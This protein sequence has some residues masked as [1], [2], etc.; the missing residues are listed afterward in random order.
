VNPHRLRLAD[1]L[2]LVAVDV[3]QTPR[4]EAG[5]EADVLLECSGNARA[6]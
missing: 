3:T 5:I 6:T 2:G 4:A 1:S